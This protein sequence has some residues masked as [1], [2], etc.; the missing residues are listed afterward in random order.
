[1]PVGRKVLLKKGGSTIVGLRT[2][3]ISW[4]GESIDVTS[5]E[6]DGKRLLLAASGQEQIDISGEGIMKE[7]QFRTLV[8]GSTS[9]LLTDVTL[10]FPILDTATNSTAATLTGDFRISSFEE[11]NPYNDASTFSLTLE[12]SGAWTYTAEAV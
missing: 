9:K 8:L 12:S 5:G 11:G 2:T 1:M 4:S 7:E 10:E 6:D 3:T